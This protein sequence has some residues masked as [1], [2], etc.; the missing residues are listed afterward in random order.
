MVLTFKNYTEIM[1]LHI[2]F[3][4][5]I[6]GKQGRLKCVLLAKVKEFNGP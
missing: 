5:L 3:K 6:S 1:Y 2:V 4:Q